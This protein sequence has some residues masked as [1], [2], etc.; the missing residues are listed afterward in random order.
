MIPAVEIDLF[1]DVVQDAISL[2]V[3]GRLSDGY[4]GL[5]V[6]VEHA[7]EMHV[8]GEPWARE[9]LDRWRAACVDYAQTFGVALS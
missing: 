6:G 1:A 8:A 3:Q 4:T 5:L 9:L 7:L 2:A